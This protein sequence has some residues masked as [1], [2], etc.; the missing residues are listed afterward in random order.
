[1]TPAI[2]GGLA[3]LCT[4]ILGSLVT[5]WVHWFI[6]LRRKKFE[7][8]GKIISDVRKILDEKTTIE[9]IMT[10]SYWGFIQDNLNEDEE[11][12]VFGEIRG[13]MLGDTT[14]IT[15]IKKREISKMLTRIEKKWQLF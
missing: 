13:Y 11:H 15:I 1:M 7:Y 4:G 5:P 9:E 8:K 12:I 14:D 6:E 10:S 3:G 2:I